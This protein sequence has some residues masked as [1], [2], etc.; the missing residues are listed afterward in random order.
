MEVEGGASGQGM[1]N[2]FQG[3]YKPTSHGQGTLWAR[4]CFRRREA[5]EGQGPGQR[6]T[7]LISSREPQRPIE[8][9]QRMRRAWTTLQG[10]EG[11]AKA[12]GWS[13]PEQWGAGQS[14]VRYTPGAQ[15][16]ATE[17]GWPC[18]IKPRSEPRTGRN[19][20]HVTT[21]KGLWHLLLN[22]GRISFCYYSDIAVPVAKP[23]DFQS[24]SFSPF[25]LCGPT[26]NSLHFSANL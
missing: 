24:G 11:K 5:D 17:W 23:V 15:S 21:R 12:P 13:W 7:E 2:G 22:T 3:L 9:G 6:P 4:P 14:S 19:W 1:L 8:G 26:I 25:M 10:C 20:H 16:S 18:S